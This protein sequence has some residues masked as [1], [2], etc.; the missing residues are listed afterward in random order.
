MITEKDIIKCEAIFNDDHTHRYLWKR[1]WNKDKPLACVIMLNPC[2]AD[3]ILTDTT[4]A[5]VVNNIARQDRFGGV[6]IVNLYSVLTNH[7]NF[8]WHPDEELNH[9]DNDTFI[10]QSANRCDVVILAWGKGATT[11][12]RITTRV[13]AVLSLL[14]PYKSKLFVLSDGERSGLHPLTPAL[15]SHWEL[16]TFSYPDSDDSAAM[17]E[18]A[19]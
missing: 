16:E 6:E 15:R 1:V 17:K 14:E 13:D 5:L 2:L 18:E 12:Q 19:G 9:A 8:R 11:H 7:L 3:N 10:Q 4:T